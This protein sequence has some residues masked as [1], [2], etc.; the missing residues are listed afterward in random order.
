MY[1]PNSGSIKVFGNVELVVDVDGTFS[2]LSLNDIEPSVSS[3]Q[4]FKIGY[5]ISTDNNTVLENTFDTYSSDGLSICNLNSSLCLLILMSDMMIDVFQ[6]DCE[7]F[8][9]P[10]VTVDRGKLLKNTYFK[11]LIQDGGKDC[12]FSKEST[13]LRT[14]Y[15]SLQILSR[16]T[17]PKKL[18]TLAAFGSTFPILDDNVCVIEIKRHLKDNFWMCAPCKK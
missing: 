11:Y 1:F 15:W 18:S 7:I 3:H 17:M 9:V 13:T 12:K 16:V 2:S 14:G 6:R 5:G 10:T 4:N 8:Q